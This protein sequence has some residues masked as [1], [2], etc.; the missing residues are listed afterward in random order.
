MT[1][2]ILIQNLK[3]KYP[4]QILEITELTKPD[5]IKNWFRL[6]E[7]EL[8]KKGAIDPNDTSQP[9]GDVYLEFNSIHI[10]LGEVGIAPV[11]SEDSFSNPLATLLFSEIQAE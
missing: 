5:N 3:N 1:A 8:I 9:C 11:F 4:N 2:K 10:Y 7:N 6:K